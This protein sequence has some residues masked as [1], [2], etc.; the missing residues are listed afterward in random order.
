MVRSCFCFIPGRV[1]G[2]GEIEAQALEGRDEEELKRIGERLPIG[3]HQTS[4]DS[5]HVEVYLASDE[6]YMVTGCVLNVD[7]GSVLD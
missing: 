2:E 5:T 3:R 1:I 4:E 7:G 6:F